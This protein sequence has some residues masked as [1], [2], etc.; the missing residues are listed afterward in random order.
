MIAYGYTWRCIHCGAENE[1]GLTQQQAEAE[2]AAE[3]DGDLG[4]IDWHYNVIAREEELH[5]EEQ[6]KCSTCDKLVL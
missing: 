2:A 6:Q 4:A 5:I 1:Y 3:W